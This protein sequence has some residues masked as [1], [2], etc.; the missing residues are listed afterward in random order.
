MNIC[1]VTNKS[2]RY[3]HQCCQKL[4][5]RCQFESSGLD[6]DCKRMMCLPLLVSSAK[7]SSALCMSYAHVLAAL[8][9]RLLS[10]GGLNSLSKSFPLVTNQPIMLRV[11]DGRNDTIN[12]L[13]IDSCMEGW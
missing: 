7:P 8:V 11:A 9:F 2:M 12:C 1:D 10:S 5:V 13:R 6:S 4:D 3:C